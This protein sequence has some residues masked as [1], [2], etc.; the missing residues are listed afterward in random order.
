MTSP[1][2]ATH[3]FL[4]I[5]QHKNRSPIF[6]GH[7]DLLVF[8]LLS[9]GLFFV[10]WGLRIVVVEPIA[11]WLLGKRSSKAKVEKFAQ[12]RV[13]SVD[14]PAYSRAPVR[15]GHPVAPEARWG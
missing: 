3:P 15:A 4:L 1:L 11:R 9:M 5:A 10:N 2:H 13:R 14:D 8:A 6:D 12:V 7:M